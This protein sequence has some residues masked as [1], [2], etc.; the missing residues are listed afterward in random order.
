MAWPRSRAVS[1]CRRRGLPRSAGTTDL[2]HLSYHEAAPGGWRGRLARSRRAQRPLSVGLPSP[3]WPSP[4]R[5]T[6]LGRHYR[7]IT[8]E[9]TVNVR[10]GGSGGDEGEARPRR[11]SRTPAVR[12]LPCT[13]TIDQKSEAAPVGGSGPLRS[14]ERRR[15]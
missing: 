1:G 15:S 7:S 3:P 8:S 6:S 5:P 2:L 4:S 13:A 11:G 12:H 9:L 14:R 10:V